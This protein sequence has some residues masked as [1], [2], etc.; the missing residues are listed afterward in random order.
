[1][2]ITNHP[3]TTAITA[4]LSIVLTACATTQQTEAIDNE[5]MLAASGFQMRLADTDEKMAHLKT[6]PQRK[7][8]PHQKGDEV[9]YV[10]ADAMYCKCIYAGPYKAYSRYQQ[11]AVNKSIEEMAVS[12]AQQD[13]P[14][15]AVDTMNWNLWTDWGP[16]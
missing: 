16:W 12:Y 5:R 8:V 1:M 6:L 2:Q 15:Q 4:A 14:M 3:K 7:L 11:M 13:N 10:Y 9:F